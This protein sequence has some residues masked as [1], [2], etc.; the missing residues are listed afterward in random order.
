MKNRLTAEDD[1]TNKNDNQR[2]TAE[3]NER[4]SPEEMMKAIKNN[5]AR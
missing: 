5:D 4:N 3:Q 2:R 1:K